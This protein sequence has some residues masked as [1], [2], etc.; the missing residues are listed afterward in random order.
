MLANGAGVNYTAGEGNPIEVMDLSF[1]TQLSS[2]SRIAAG[3]DAVGVHVL[4][5]AAERLVAAAALEAHGAATDPSGGGAVR[6][7]GAAQ[8]WT[9]HRYRATDSLG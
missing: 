6:P 2:L 9:A 4:D 5:A 8:H 7:G 1:A 3:G